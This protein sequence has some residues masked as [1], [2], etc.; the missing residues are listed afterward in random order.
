[1]ELQVKPTWILV[2]RRDGATI[3]SSH[4]ARDPLSIIREIEHPAGRL[5]AAE[6]ESDRPGRAFDRGGQG[7]H[8]LSSEESPTE[9]IEHR[10]VTALARELDHSRHDGSF[11]ELVLVAG[12]KLLGKLRSALSDSTRKLVIAELPKDL[13]A[14]TASE[15]REHLAGVAR[16]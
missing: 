12:P 13:R 9:H 10:F 11:S 16:V 3:F 14:P 15:L 5:H 8:A 1:M 2:A 7:R 6:I 4:G